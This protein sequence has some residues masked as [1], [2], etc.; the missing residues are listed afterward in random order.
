MSLRILQQKDEAIWW[1][2]VPAAIYVAMIRKPD[3]SRNYDDTE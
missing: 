1:R 2:H 3:E